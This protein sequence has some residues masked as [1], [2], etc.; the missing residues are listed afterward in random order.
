MSFNTPIYRDTCNILNEIYTNQALY[1]FLS[2]YQLDIIK[3]WYDMVSNYNM[4]N[5]DDAK[6]FANLQNEV[7]GIANSIHLATIS[8]INI[9]HF[10]VKTIRNHPEVRIKRYHNEFASVVR[11]IKLET[12]NSIRED[13]Y[14]HMIYS[15]VDFYNG[16]MSYLDTLGI[17]LDS[18][19]TV[20]RNNE[21]II[22]VKNGLN[23]SVVLEN[24]SDDRLLYDVV[25]NLY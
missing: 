17:I 2:K 10:C 23:P 13:Y 1:S 16:K 25:N 4:W 6:Q 14:N 12:L 21:Q 3:K 24:A 20:E 15:L 9:Y 11:L 8:R 18:F 7:Y 19:L 22:S 5:D